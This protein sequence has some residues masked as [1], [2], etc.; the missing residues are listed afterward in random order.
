LTNNFLHFTNN[1][2]SLGETFITG[3]GGK[4]LEHIYLM[5]KQ[6]NFLFN[7]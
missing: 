3:G 1:Y 5:G 4:G 2:I 6:R 7:I